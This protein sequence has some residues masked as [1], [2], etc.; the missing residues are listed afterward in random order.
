LE[1]E[2]GENGCGAETI[3]IRPGSVL[4][5]VSAP[6]L[7]QPAP[8]PTIGKKKPVNLHFLLKN[9]IQFGKVVT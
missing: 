6:P 5:K 1:G 4:Y 7:R 2:G 9:L 3:C 8:A